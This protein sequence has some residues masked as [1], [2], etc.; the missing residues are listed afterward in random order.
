MHSFIKIINRLIDKIKNIIIKIRLVDRT[1]LNQTNGI[2]RRLVIII[3]NHLAL[4]VD[5]LFIR[6]FFNVFYLSGKDWKELV[7]VGSRC[8]I[9]SFQ[10][11]TLRNLR[12]KNRHY[13][14]L[15]C[16]KT[17]LA[18]IM[19][20][21]EES[22]NELNEILCNP[23]NIIR[24]ETLKSAVDNCFLKEFEKFQEQQKQKDIDEINSIELVF[25]EWLGFFD[26]KFLNQHAS[27]NSK[28][29]KNKK[30]KTSNEISIKFFIL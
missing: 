23:N 27:N 10:K 9:D 19:K 6:I 21:I 24:F 25:L 28:Q 3:H 17:E 13:V 7:R 30:Q 5:I 11:F 20:S 8:K 14:T 26:S 29:P 1:K 15:K 22:Q 2:I 4:S 16:L 12:Y 18:T